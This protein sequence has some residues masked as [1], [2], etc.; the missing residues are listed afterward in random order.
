MSAMHHD[1]VLARTS[2]LPHL[3][4]YNLVAQLSNHNDN[5]DIFRFAAGGFR[6]FTRIAASDPTMWHDIF[7]ANKPALLSAVDEFTAQLGQLR[8]IIE[9]NDSEQL[10]GV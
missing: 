2:H 1:N 5:M 6:D 7:Y 8:T 3:L 9:N 4:A 10:L